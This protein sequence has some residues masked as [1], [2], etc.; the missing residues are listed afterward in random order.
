LVHAPPSSASTTTPAQGRIQRAGRAPASAATGTAA[1]A[2]NS[3]NSALEGPAERI[4]RPMKALRANGSINRTAGR[5]SAVARSGR[6]GR[7]S[8]A[9][10]APISGH[11]NMYV[12]PGASAA[13]GISSSAPSTSPPAAKLVSDPNLRASVIAPR[14]S[15]SVMPKYATMYQSRL[16]TSPCGS[17]S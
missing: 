8:S 2:S 7:A 17:A 12:P 16:Y 13:T 1:S 3:A 15:A 14:N 10:V 6:F 11:S 5:H 9:S 4:I